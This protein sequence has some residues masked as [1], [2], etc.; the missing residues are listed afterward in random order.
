[1]ADFTLSFL[2]TTA[3]PYTPPGSMTVQVGSWRTAAA[4]GARASANGVVAQM[5]HNVAYGGVIRSDIT[6]NTLSAGDAPAACVLVR[7]GGNANKGY[8]AYSTGSTIILAKLDASGNLSDISGTIVAYTPAANDV[9]SCIYTTATGSLQSLVN[10]VAK[11]TTTDTTFQAEASLAAGLL[12]SAA[13]VNG[14]FIS[15]FA[16]TGV[17]SGAFSLSVANL[18][19]SL[20]LQSQ[21]LT[22]PNPAALNAAQI[23]YSY[24]LQSEALGSAMPASTIVYSLSLVNESLSNTSNYITFPA[25]VSYSY[26]IGAQVSDVQLDVSPLSYGYTLQNVSLQIPLPAITSAGGTFDSLTP[27]PGLML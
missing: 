2:G 20:A 18:S 9:I 23:T 13:N 15:Q 11:A 8:A 27:M 12:D 17:A 22:G 10:N 5:V 19:Y 25:P 14:T 7:S 1:M 6:I 16:G 24:A 26:A 21:T 4:T 3:N